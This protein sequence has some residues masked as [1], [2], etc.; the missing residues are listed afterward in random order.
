MVRP[1]YRQHKRP[2]PDSA[3]VPKTIGNRFSRLQ[4]DLSHPNPA[5][6]DA[7]DLPLLERN[8]LLFWQSLS[9]LLLLINLVLFFLLGR[10]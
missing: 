9:G 3:S 6:K 5:F 8:P 4:Y 7:S 1:E 2:F 10:Q